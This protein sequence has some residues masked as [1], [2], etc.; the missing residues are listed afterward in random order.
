MMTK[1][2]FEAFAYRG[3]DLDGNAIDPDA[4]NQAVTARVRIYM[5]SVDGQEL[6]VFSTAPTRLK[7]P[8]T[9]VRA[10]AFSDDNGRTDGAYFDAYLAEATGRVVMA[11]NTPGIDYYADT[12]VTKQLGQ[13]TPEQKE[14]LRMVGSFRKVGEASMRAL[15][16]A[17]VMYDIEDHPFIVTASSMGVA[18]AG[19]MLREAFES[20]TKIAGIVMAEPVNHI[21]RPLGRL[22]K[23]FLGANKTAGGYVDVNPHPINQMEPGVRFVRRVVHGGEANIAYARALGAGTLRRDLGEI[24]PMAD[25]K[26]PTYLTRGTASR[27]SASKNGREFEELAEYLQPNDALAI[28]RFEGHDHPYTMTVQ[29]VIDGIEN[30]TNA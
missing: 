12:D 9:I 24:D 4:V 11:V 8:E 19:G 18:V 20:D 13:L 29:S 16:A 10:T 23:E 7:Y 25:L 5:P 1:P 30:V 15:N 28:D 14:E 3:V 27:L 26:M 2:R 6:A 21:R 17:A 22:G